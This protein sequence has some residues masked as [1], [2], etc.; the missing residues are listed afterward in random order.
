M[1]AAA[2]GLVLA[3]TASIVASAEK[4]RHLTGPQI[5]DRFVGMELGDDVL[6]RDSFWLG[7]KIDLLVQSSVNVA[8]FC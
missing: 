5:R 6:W 3:G 1:A 7:M 8:C 4:L 2:A